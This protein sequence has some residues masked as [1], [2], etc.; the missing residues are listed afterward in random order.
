MNDEESCEDV[1]EGLTLVGD[2][3]GR[4]YLDEVWFCG[5]GQLGYYYVEEGREMR[6][7]FGT[8]LNI[9]LCRAVGGLFVR[10]QRLMDQRE[11]VDFHRL[12]GRVTFQ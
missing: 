9:S 7:D 5:G 6:L 12:R 8:C 11:F 4:G 1:Q 2:E 10:G 3:P